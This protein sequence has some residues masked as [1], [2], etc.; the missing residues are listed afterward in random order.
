MQTLR[1]SRQNRA[2]GPLLDVLSEEDLE[3]INALQI[4]PRVTWQDAGAILGVRPATLAAR[5]E[6][7]ESQGLAWITSYGV[8][9]PTEMTL[10][11]VD[12]DCSP[13]TVMSVADAL[14][15]IPEVQTVELPAGHH[16]AML[17]VFTRSLYDYANVV[18][19]AILAIPGVER[20]HAALGSTLHQAGHSW[21]IPALDAKKSAAFAQL[22]ERPRSSGPLTPACHDLL[23]LL[24]R[25]GRASS[26]QMAKELGRNPSTVQR[27]LAKVLG[28]GLVAF[29]CDVAQLAVGFPATCTWYAKVPSGQHTAAAAAIR[30]IRSVRLSASITGRANFI[31]TMWLRS[32]AEVAAAEM[33]MAEK[34]PGIEFLESIVVLRVTKRMGVLV[35]P[36]SRARGR[37]DLAPAAIPAG[38]D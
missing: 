30:S 5:W 29:R 27:Q 12:V 9:D 36:D 22:A 16:D 20:I 25:D 15:A 3:L 18:A 21:R 4:A 23:P 37:V 35:G 7:L 10:A 28:S 34:V 26:A 17:T 38:L 13:G 14:N 24:A 8:G 31:V 1:P 6:R 19:P 33:A 2:D 11:F 32:V